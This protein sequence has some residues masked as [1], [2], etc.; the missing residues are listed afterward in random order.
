MEHM[1]TTWMQRRT[2]ITSHEVLE[3]KKKKLN[4]S[5]PLIWTKPYQT[6]S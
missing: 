5:A 3:L 2:A 4:M 6:K 1:T